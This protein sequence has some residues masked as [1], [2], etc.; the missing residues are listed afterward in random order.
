MLPR[1]RAEAT[2]D[3]FPWRILSGRRHAAYWP[4]TSAAASHILGYACVMLCAAKL[5]RETR[6]MA[7]GGQQRTIPARPNFKRG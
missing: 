5:L 4:E 6:S 1:V 7:H 3:P 2:P